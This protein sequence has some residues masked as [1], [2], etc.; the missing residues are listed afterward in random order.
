MCQ[1]EALKNNL[2]VYACTG[3]ADGVAGDMILIAPPLVITEEQVDELV[4][5]LVETI[6]AMNSN[7]PEM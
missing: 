5:L 7:L 1:R 3:S 2:V 4:G 6:L